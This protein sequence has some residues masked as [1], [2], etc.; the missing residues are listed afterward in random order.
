MKARFISSDILQFVHILHVYVKPNGF[1]QFTFTI[2]K[3]CQH[4]F[5]R[6]VDFVNYL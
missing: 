4:L 1:E 2:F 6:F 3:M 5:D